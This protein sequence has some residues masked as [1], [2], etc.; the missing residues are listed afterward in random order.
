MIFDI[1]MGL[2]VSA[3]SL[4]LYF[5]Y[6]K[7]GKTLEEARSA[8]LLSLLISNMGFVTWN[9]YPYLGRKLLLGLSGILAI[10]AGCLLSTKIQKTLYLSP[11]GGEELFMTMM[12]TVLIWILVILGRVVFKGRN[13]NNT[14]PNKRV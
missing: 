9:S 14:I 7:I 13:L 2:F 5:Y 4:G 3:W 11:L 6:L 8:A 10:I 1:A 12:G